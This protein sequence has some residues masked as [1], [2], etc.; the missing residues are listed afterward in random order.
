MTW[1]ST[2]PSCVIIWIIQYSIW[3]M[4]AVL[5]LVNKYDKTYK[6]NVTTTATTTTNNNVNILTGCT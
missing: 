1:H 6:D 4:H 5:W 3:Y 2:S